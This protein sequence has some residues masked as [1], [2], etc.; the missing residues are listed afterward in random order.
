MY[1][2][3]ATGVDAWGRAGSGI[4]LFNDET[5]LVEYFSIDEVNLLSGFGVSSCTLYKK[6]FSNGVYLIE[7]ILGKHGYG[8]VNDGELQQFLT[9][10][11]KVCESS[12][13]EPIPRNILFNL[14]KSSKALMHKVLAIVD[15]NG[16]L[17]YLDP[18]KA[19]TIRLSEICRTVTYASL[20]HENRDVTYIF[21]NNLEAVDTDCFID[22]GQGSIPNV[23]IEGDPK[24][25]YFGRRVNY[26]SSSSGESK[27]SQG[28]G[29]LSGIFGRNS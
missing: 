24:K 5:H 3:L 17:W 25:F 27:K 9:A 12:M 26:V 20:V 22:K 15:T 14:A 28:K 21:D 11:D 8:F 18:D 23:K 10:G 7:D 1:Q 19:Q 4:V 16:R 13:V 2:V 29:W 6:T